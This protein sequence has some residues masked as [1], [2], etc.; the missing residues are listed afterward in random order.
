MDEF[1]LFFRMGPNRSYLSDS[2]SRSQVRE[3]EFGRCKD[4]VTVV[5]ACN[6]DELHRKPVTYIGS[7]KKS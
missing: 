7:A 1:G 3:T 2:E 4:I 6:A 5:L